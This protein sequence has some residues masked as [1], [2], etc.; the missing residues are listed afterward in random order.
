LTR[1]V[2]LWIDHRKAVIV[3]ITEKMEE[4]KSVTSGIEK[5]VRFSG[6]AQA[7]TEE[8]IQDNRFTN[9]LNKYYDEVLLHLRGADSIF[10]VGP[11]EAKFEFNKRLEGD[12]QIG[13][14]AVIEVADKLTESQLLSKV[15]AHFSK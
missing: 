11:G 4:I 9:H 14:V 8:D 5:H 2:G 10:I 1:N 15:R 3:T 13:K 6:E 7:D 12:N